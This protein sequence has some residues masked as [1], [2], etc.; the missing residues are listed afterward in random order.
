MNHIELEIC[1]A[2]LQSLRAAID[3][4]AQ[5]VELC[6]A[7]SLDGL[8][9]SAGMIEMAVSSGI[10]THVLIRPREGD[11]VYSPD[12]VEC[13]VH[14]I[15]MAR[16][17]GAHGIVIGALTP[18]GDIDIPTC[19]RLADEAKG[20]N[21]TFHR[22][23][24]VCRHPMDALKQIHALGCNR[25]LTSGLA[26]TAE[27]GIAMLKQLVVEAN[28]LTQQAGHPLLIMPGAGVSA[29]NAHHILCETGATQIHGSLRKNG[30]TDAETVRLTVQSIQSL[31]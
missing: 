12:E 18:D 9:P 2:D 11:F 13:M 14:D 1:C 6:Q 23:F 31:S 5:R 10:T 15:R 17:L 20:M 28:R 4:G 24:D 27:Q 16:Q 25:L 26:P 19:Q 30:H 22:A 3:G 7:L 21:I 8:T 29:S